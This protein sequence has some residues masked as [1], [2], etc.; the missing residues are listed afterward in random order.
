MRDSEIIRSLTRMIKG[1]VDEDD[2][3]YTNFPFTPNELFEGVK[4]GPMCELYNCISMTLH[5]SI[6][7]NES[8]YC[9]TSSRYLANKIWALA[10]DWEALIRRGPS[11]RNPKQVLMGMN[12]HQLTRSTKIINYLCKSNFCIPYRDILKQN[13]AWDEMVKEGVASTSQLRK[14]MVTHSNIIWI[15]RR[16]LYQF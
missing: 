2:F 5:S 10:C 16:N 6:S 1:K 11:Y 14:G 8:G 4:I 13:K 9:V 7:P 3:L 12:I 15:K